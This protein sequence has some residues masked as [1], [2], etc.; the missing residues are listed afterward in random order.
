MLNKP[1]I[2]NS[3]RT[4]DSCRLMLRLS[5]EIIYFDGHFPGT[6]ILAGVV[7]LNW[8]V[9]YA[10]EYLSLQGSDVGSVEV[11][12]FQQVLA[13][14]TDVVLSLTRKAEDKFVFDYSSEVGNH[15][16]GRIKLKADS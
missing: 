1:E 9:E 15:S 12:K 2:I 16:S 6:P 10:L 5:P 8:A 14:N 4:D 11:L 7:Q 13:P 3:E